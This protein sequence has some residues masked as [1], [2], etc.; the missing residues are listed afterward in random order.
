MAGSAPVQS[1]EHYPARMHK[2]PMFR[3]ALIVALSML[4]FAAALPAYGLDGALDPSFGV[5]GRLV[6]TRRFGVVPLA[7]GR[8]VMDVPPASQLERL[9]PNGDVDTSFGRNGYVSGSSSQ[10]PG[11][12]FLPDAG[13]LRKPLAGVCWSMGASE[14]PRSGI[15]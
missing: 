3:V 9:L 7:D 5:G 10:Q 12:P 4:P 2:V 1:R 14:A 11:M 8:L 15:S 6:T 13:P